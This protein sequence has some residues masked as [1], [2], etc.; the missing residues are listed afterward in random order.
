MTQEEAVARAVAD[1]IEEI[2]RGSLEPGNGQGWL[3]EQLRAMPRRV[4]RAAIAAMPP[5]DHA[6]SV[7]DQIREWVNRQGSDIQPGELLRFMDTIVPNS[8]GLASGEP[9]RCLSGED[10]L[11]ASA[12][13][14]LA[15]RSS[16]GSGILDEV[17]EVL[18]ELLPGTLCGENYQ[19]PMPEGLLIQTYHLSWGKV[20]RG[21]ALFDKISAI[22][23][24]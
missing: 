6:Y 19:P 16:D 4:A 13:P 1:E 9:E 12:G 23:R 8:T 22:T 2:H 17:R 14:G 5:R 20:R 21:R 24:S 3:W 10:A 7:A 15:S 18:G 11:L